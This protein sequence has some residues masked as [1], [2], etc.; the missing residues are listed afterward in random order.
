MKRKGNEGSH[1]YR[2]YSSLP[3]WGNV[4]QHYSGYGNRHSQILLMVLQ[5]GTVPMYGD[6]ATA[7][8]M[9]PCALCFNNLIYKVSSQIY[10]HN[11][12]C[13]M[14]ESVYGALFITF[15]VSKILEPT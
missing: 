9:D 14:F 2:D 4:C 11:T 5:H 3:D 7:S 10:Q 8:K 15:Y 6:M 12:K 1:P 13:R